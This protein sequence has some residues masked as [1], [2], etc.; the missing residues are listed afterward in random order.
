MSVHFEMMT[1]QVALR[2]AIIAGKRSGCQKSRRGV[3]IFQP[4]DQRLQPIM[5]FGTNG[6]PRPFLC[7]DDVH[8]R[9]VC[10][11]I[12]VHAEEAALLMAGQQARGAELLHIKLVWAGSSPI[13]EGVHAEVVHSRGP[14]CWQCSRAILHAGISRVWLLHS[15]EFAFAPGTVSPWCL[16]RCKRAPLV[17]T[18]SS[19]VVA[20][21]GLLFGYPAEEFHRL[22]LISC[23]LLPE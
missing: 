8:C 1:E 23:G 9:S 20:G 16:D 2:H 15:Q 11:K 12:C 21:G 4:G 5:G 18:V 7:T 22:T 3:V 6:P 17:R 19:E 13:P 10:N 14:S